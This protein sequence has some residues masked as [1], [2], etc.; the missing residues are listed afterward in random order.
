M[1]QH[2]FDQFLFRCTGI[3]EQ[4]DL[5]DNYVSD[6]WQY[7]IVLENTSCVADLMHCQKNNIA[8]ILLTSSDSPT[9][10]FRDT[11][12]CR[13]FSNVTFENASCIENVTGFCMS[14]F[15][16][17]VYLKK[18]SISQNQ[19]NGMILKNTLTED[20]KAFK[21]ALCGL[22]VKSIHQSA[23]SQSESIT[24]RGGNNQS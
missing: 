20:Q 8:G 15:F 3:P 12:D 18:C 5:Q 22:A 16:G 11:E 13:L 10:D 24:E 23:K 6:C 14:D 2:D 21:D 17:F 7:G 9:K 4:I 19:E 1:N